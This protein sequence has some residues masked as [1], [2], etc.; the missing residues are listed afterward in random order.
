MKGLILVL[1]LVLA[2]TAL[3][4][5]K[6]YQ[7]EVFVKWNLART[8]PYLFSVIL[9]Q[10]MDSK[11]FEDYWGYV[12]YCTLTSFDSNSMDEYDCPDEF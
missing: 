3:A 12:Y 10:L 6:E 4:D 9:T 2:A 5:Y 11:L 1:G 8:N 7:D